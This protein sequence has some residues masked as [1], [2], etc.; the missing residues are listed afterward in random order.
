MPR[1]FGDSLVHISEVHAIVENH[2]PLV[3]VPYKDPDPDSMGL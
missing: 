1:V 2:I 3:N